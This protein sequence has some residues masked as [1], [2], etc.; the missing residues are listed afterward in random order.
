MT[1]EYRKLFVLAVV[2]SS[3]F[4]PGNAMCYVR[5][6]TLGDALATTTNAC[7][8]MAASWQLWGWETVLPNDYWSALIVT[9][10]LWSCTAIV[11]LFS[12]IQTRVIAVSYYR[13]RVARLGILRRLL[14][15]FGFAWFGENP[16]KL[17]TVRTVVAGDSSLAIRPKRSLLLWSGLA[18]IGLG[19]AGG[20]QIGSGGII[21]YVSIRLF[22]IG[23]L[24]IAG[25]AIDSFVHTQRRKHI[26]VGGRDP[27]ECVSCGYNLRDLPEK[28]CPEC[29]A[30]FGNADVAADESEAHARRIDDEKSGAI[31]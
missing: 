6:R 30:E 13:A 14:F 5:Y 18:L 22:S 8:I 26:V 20:T 27:A 4:L 10:I 29:G 21:S 17:E 3:V 19:V 25:F 24:C 28:R 23:V 31:E 12:F 1:E 15:I 2:V 11:L 16:A 9:V 7:I